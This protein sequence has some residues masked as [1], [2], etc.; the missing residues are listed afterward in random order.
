MLLLQHLGLMLQEAADVGF[1]SGGTGTSSTSPGVSTDGDDKPER[2]VGIPTVTA[3]VRVNFLE[4]LKRIM[5]C[6]RDERQRSLRNRLREQ[7]R[8]STFLCLG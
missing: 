2:E 8:F 5:N 3:V 4:L 7:K 1:V 6:E